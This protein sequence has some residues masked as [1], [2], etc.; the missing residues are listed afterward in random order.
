MPA[1]FNDNP[2]SS[3][4]V[5]LC[6]IQKTNSDYMTDV[7]ISTTMEPTPGGIE[8]MI[9]KFPQSCEPSTVLALLDKIRNSIQGACNW[10][11]NL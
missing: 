7:K 9:L 5:H 8:A 1:S 11:N 6:F 4:S 2:A 3:H 10:R